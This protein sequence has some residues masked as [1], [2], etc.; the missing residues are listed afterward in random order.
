MSHFETTPTS[1]LPNFVGKE[2]CHT[3]DKMHRKIRTAVRNDTATEKAVELPAYQCGHIWMFPM[4]MKERDK[5][6]QISVSLWLTIN[7]IQ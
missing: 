2:P 5:R 7:V 1:G 4:G 6:C 3:P